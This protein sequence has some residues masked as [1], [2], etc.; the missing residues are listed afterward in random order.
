MRS[1]PLGCRTTNTFI[2]GNGELGVGGSTAG[3][4]RCDNLL[5]TLPLFELARVLV[6]L[7]HVASFIINA[8]HSIVW[9]AEKLCV[10]DCIGWLRFGSA[11]HRPP[12]GN[13]FG[14]QI[15]PTSIFGLI[16]NNVLQLLGSSFSSRRPTGLHQLGKPL[17]SSRGDSTLFFG[18]GRSTHLLTSLQSGPTSSG[19]RRE[20]STG[21]RRHRS[22]VGFGLYTWRS[23]REEW[24]EASFQSIYLSTDRDRFLQSSKRQF[25]T[26]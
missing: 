25:H 10:A 1:T 23:S 6:R 22:S 12:N 4:R 8:N 26:Y 24:S 9:A 15:D 17:P 7:N 19:G 18:R 20:F 14:N 16:E 21:R 5:A 11:Y 2:N 3:N 13:T